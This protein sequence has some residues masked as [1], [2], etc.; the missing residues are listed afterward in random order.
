MPPKERAFDRGSRRGRGLVLEL[1]KELRIARIGHGLS[2]ETV[3]DAVGLS[4]SEV[5]RI[6]RGQVV[7]VSLLNLARLLSVVGLDLTARAYPTGTTLRD[8][9]QVALLRRLQAELAANLK[10]RTEVPVGPS[11]DLRAWDAVIG[12]G[13][14]RI[15]VEAETRLIDLQAV[16]RRLALRCRDSAIQHA[17]LLL[18]DT[19]TNRAAAQSFEP[20]I[21]GSFPI[22]GREA[23]ADLRA[24]RTP[25]GSALILL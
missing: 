9:A 3:G 7:S 1:A 16:E 22:G 13:P 4:G 2:Q 25:A 21:R 19:R 20:S 14:D 8:K 5:G 6:E 18:A 24:G 15:G 10:W 17:I 23:L 12:D 11:G